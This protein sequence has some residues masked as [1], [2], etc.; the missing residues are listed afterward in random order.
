[1]SGIYAVDLLHWGNHLTDDEIDLAI[2]WCDAQVPEPELRRA[3]QR[4]R[5][6][7]ST[8][9]TAV[10]AANL[11]RKL[12]VVDR[13][14]ASLP[15]NSDAPTATLLD[16]VIYGG[17]LT[18]YGV[19]SHLEKFGADLEAFT[20]EYLGEAPLGLACR[21]LRYV[22]DGLKEQ[23]QLRGHVEALMGTWKKDSAALLDAARL[24]LAQAV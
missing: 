10:T 3:V 6:S 12:T 9:D 8:S 22:I 11:R 14:T 19:D 15:R 18:A 23:P 1:M 24:M 4:A 21:E 20:L 17:M 13:R 5:S 16:L 2:R 7:A